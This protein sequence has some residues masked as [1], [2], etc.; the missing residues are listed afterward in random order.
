MSRCQATRIENIED[1]RHVITNYK[2][3][4]LA[5]A[6]KFFVVTVFESQI[7]HTANPDPVSSQ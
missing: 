4:E 7:N 3:C 1:L 6:P 2:V 5:I